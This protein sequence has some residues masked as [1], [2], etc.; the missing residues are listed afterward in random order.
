MFCHWLCWCWTWIA[1]VRE[2]SQ[3]SVCYAIGRVP[4][5]SYGEFVWKEYSPGSSFACVR[6]PEVFLL[7][8]WFLQLQTSRCS[9][10][11][12]LVGIM[13]NLSIPVFL[14][15]GWGLSWEFL[16]SRRNLIENILE[17]SSTPE[18]SLHSQK[19]HSDR[20]STRYASNNPF[21]LPRLKN[22]KLNGFV[23]NL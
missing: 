9:R 21:V 22:L 6:I 7:L 12:L 13:S 2:Y 18:Y 5:C 20:V 16:Q 8:H 4:R 17:H 15:G 23:M 11:F 3:S 1:V 14:Y 19:C 10:P